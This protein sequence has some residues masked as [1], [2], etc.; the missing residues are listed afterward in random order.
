MHRGVPMIRSFIWW[1]GVVICAT[2]Q[3]LV[4]WFYYASTLGRGKKL[5]QVKMMANIAWFMVTSWRVRQKTDAKA[6]ADMEHI[7]E[8]MRK[9]LGKK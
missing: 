7:E 6:N 9:V 8:T 3:Q 2:L 5:P 4:Y 1:L